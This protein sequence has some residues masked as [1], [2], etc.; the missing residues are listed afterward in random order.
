MLL[1]GITQQSDFAVLVGKAPVACV[2]LEE[3]TALN[4]SGMLEAPTFRM[5]G[6]PGKRLDWGDLIMG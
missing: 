3:S 6:Y 4:L 1:T 2:N 5:T